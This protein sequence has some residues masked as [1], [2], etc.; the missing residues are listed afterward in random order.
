MYNSHAVHQSEQDHAQGIRQPR[1][2]IPHRHGDALFDVDAE[3]V[4]F[5]LGPCASSAEKEKETRK[6]RGCF[7]PLCTFSKSTPL[8]DRILM[9]MQ[10]ASTAQV[11]VPLILNGV[12]WP[13]RDAVRAEWRRMEADGLLTEYTV[14]VG[15][16]RKHCKVLELTPRGRETVVGAR[17][18]P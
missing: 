6:A 3:A 18:N 15:K 12:R 5:R 7:A 11:R 8:R 1:N 9:R 4:Q 10:A 14:L 16:V 13:D 2:F 17:G